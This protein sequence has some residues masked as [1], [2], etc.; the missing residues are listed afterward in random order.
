MSP[1][2]LILEGK[3]CDLVFELLNIISFVFSRDLYSI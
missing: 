3:S 2:Y 1:W